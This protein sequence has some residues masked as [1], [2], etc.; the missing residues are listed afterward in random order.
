MA[1][2]LMQQQLEGRAAAVALTVEAAGEVAV[3]AWAGVLQ[4][5]AGFPAGWPPGHCQAVGV[6]C[7]PLRPWGHPTPGRRHRYRES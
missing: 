5:C 1:A 3:P 6:P 2:A 7:C 4:A